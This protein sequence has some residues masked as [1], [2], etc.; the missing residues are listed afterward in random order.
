ML[1]YAKIENEETKQ[2]SV[3]LGTNTEFYKSIGMVEM[4]V[5]QAYDG[6]WYLTGYAPEKPAPTKEE[7]SEIRH[8]LY[9]SE[10]DP[11]KYDYE[12]CLAR[13]GE[14][15]QQTVDAKNIWLAKKD[16]IRESN[17]YPVEE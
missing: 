13:Y 2:V 10:A 6:S 16:E 5:E 4:D 17:P 7:I 15:N 1:K 12:E 8:Q 9:V 14:G 11:L 3:G